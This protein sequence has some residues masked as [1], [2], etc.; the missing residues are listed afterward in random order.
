M[1]EGNP[2]RIG[3]NSARAN[4]VPMVVLWA[5]AALLATGYY[6]IP[7]VAGV[8][9]PV[10]EFQVRGGWVAPFLN[11]V[12]FCGI[13]PGIFLLSI[14]S[15]R[16]R[17]P[18]VVIGVQSVWNG[19]MGIAGDWAFRLLNAMFGG[20]VDMWT[21]VLKTAMDQ[22]VWTVLFIAPANAIFYFWVARDF[23][24]LRTFRDWPRRFYGELVA[25]NLL[26]NW[27]V[28]IPVQFATF[29]FPVDLQI[30]VNGFICAFWILMCLQ[31]GGRTGRI[32]CA[33]D[34]A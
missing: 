3:W 21:L 7:G 22:F 5:M 6:F 24:L 16:R 28:W 26:S 17:R 12:V 27:A 11:R 10:R 32:A 23:S 2:F 13:L 1:S 18:F 20:G 31:I 25:P 15:I 34:W 14:Q 30:H 33:T 8:L 29:L 4:A 19:L 9:E